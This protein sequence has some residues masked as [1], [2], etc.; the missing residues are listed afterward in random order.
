M[1]GPCL[2]AKLKKP[3]AK[4][5]FLRKSGQIEM[6]RILDNIVGFF[7]NCL[8]FECGNI[9]I[10]NPYHL[11]TQSDL[12]AIW[13]DSECNWPNILRKK[14]DAFIWIDKIMRGNRNGGIK[15]NYYKLFWRKYVTIWTK[16]ITANLNKIKSCIKVICK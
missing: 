12:S 11:E 14:L 8:S 5:K 7:S 16:W 9:A 2:H 3:K 13:C 15:L 10:L 1:C 6:C 4:N